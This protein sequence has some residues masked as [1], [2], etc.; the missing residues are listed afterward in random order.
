MPKRKKY[1][2][3]IVA[4]IVSAI[5]GY[6]TCIGLHEL[7]RQQIAM[8]ERAKQQELY[9]AKVASLEAAM[10]SVTRYLNEVSRQPA[11]MGVH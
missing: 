11:G 8:D 5:L 3:I 7:E 9:E 4:C 1:W 10:Q 6:S 2:P